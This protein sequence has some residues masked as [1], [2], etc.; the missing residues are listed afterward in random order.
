MSRI[1]PV[2]LTLLSATAVANISAV[3]R[4]PAI[5]GLFG[6]LGTPLEVL[7]EPLHFSCTAVA[8]E[9]V[10]RF[11]ATYAITNPTARAWSSRRGPRRRVRDAA[12]EGTTRWP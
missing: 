12:S 8:N 10:C 2:G 3:R 1:F 5:G 7:F 6:T 11:V 4:D 9:P